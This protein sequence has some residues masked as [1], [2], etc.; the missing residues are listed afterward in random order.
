M[1][2]PMPTPGP[3][4]PIGTF[5]AA[6]EHFE[7]HGDPAAFRTAAGAVTSGGHPQAP[8]YA[9][10]LAHADRLA[11]GTLGMHEDESWSKIGGRVKE[12]V[13]AL[14]GEAAKVP[15]AVA[16]DVGDMA[17][18]AGRYVRDFFTR[19]RNRG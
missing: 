4:H 15:A 6:A 11:R 17:K 19:L 14:P 10:L 16:A 7:R 12:D 9:R 5:R 2:M 18:E 1:P 8:I 3:N 13:K